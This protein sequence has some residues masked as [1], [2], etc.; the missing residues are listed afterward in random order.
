ML[1]RPIKL[2]NAKGYFSR[3]TYHPWYHISEDFN[4]TDE[5]PLSAEPQGSC[6]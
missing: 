5:P 4:D 6:P 2:I 1:G 3:E